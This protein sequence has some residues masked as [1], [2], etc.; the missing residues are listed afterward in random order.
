ME[1]LLIA[2]YTT[3]QQPS[4]QLCAAA[5]PLVLPAFPRDAD[6]SIDLDMLRSSSLDTLQRPAMVHGSAHRSVV[7]SK[8]SDAEQEALVLSALREELIGVELTAHTDLLSSA[9]IDSVAAAGITNGCGPRRYCPSTPVSRAQMAAFLR[10][11]LT[12]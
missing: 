11:A 8:T 4:A 10:R 5:N 12:R 9:A 7:G 3:A 6:G 2:N 1:N